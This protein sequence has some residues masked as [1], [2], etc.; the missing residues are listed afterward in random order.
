MS[1]NQ[2]LILLTTDQLRVAVRAEPE[3]ELEAVEVVGLNSKI[4]NSNDACILYVYPW[5]Y[6]IH[7][8]CCGCLSIIVSPNDDHGSCDGDEVN[9][10]HQNVS[11]QMS[12][13]LSIV[14]IQ[15]MLDSLWYRH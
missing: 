12:V 13:A 3:I 4:Q 1:Q 11:P 6:R 14:Y 5:V 8:S 10:N 15:P 7:A 9:S 2:N